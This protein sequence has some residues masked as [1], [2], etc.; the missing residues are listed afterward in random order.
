MSG[1]RP[2]GVHAGPRSNPAEQILSVSLPPRAYNLI[3]AEFTALVPTAAPI[4]CVLGISA[5]ATGDLFLDPAWRGFARR[6]SALLLLYDVQ[7]P[8][9]DGRITDVAPDNDGF[10]ALMAALAEIGEQRAHPELER[11]P[12]L[13][14]GLSKSA[15]QAAQYAR[16]AGERALAAI[17]YHY[18]AGLRLP[19]A[20]I[21]RIAH[22]PVLCPFAEQDSIFPPEMMGHQ[23]A[24]VFS[25]HPRAA[26]A[27]VHRKNLLHHE[28]GDP[29]FP[30][31]WLESILTL[32]L[33]ERVGDPLRTLDPATGVTA[34]LEVDA[35]GRVLCR[36]AP[37][38]SQV[39]KPS[40]RQWLPS[41]AV[42]E[43][44]LA[45]QTADARRVNAGGPAES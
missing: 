40:F 36:L 13:F 17:C 14:T 5:Y 8:K 37:S 35:S 39:I 21:S 15:E 29:T 27:G 18:P 44:W 31:Q 19:E 45:A 6:H 34:V 12:L 9:I 1:A 42:A 33:P 16:L 43:A 25:Q 7:K 23:N 28:P 22:L 11:A 41:L 20:A 4:R 3:K 24:F 38:G 2:G 30:L 10:S 26:W 32:R